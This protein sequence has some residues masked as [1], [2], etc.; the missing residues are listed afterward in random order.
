MMLGA[1][2]L[3]WASRDYSVV[4]P[5]WDGQ[6]RGIA[7]TPSHLYSDA[8]LKNVTPDQI[9]RDLTQLSQ[10]TGRIRTYTVAGGMDKVPQIARR[11][12]MTVTLGLYLTPDLE[13]NEKE[14][15]LGIKTALANRRTIDRVVVGNE[16]QVFGLVSPEQ[17]NAY[18]LR[19]RDALPARI[20]VTTAEPWSTWVL[21]WVPELPKIELPE[22]ELPPPPPPPLLLLLPP[23]LPPPLLV[24]DSAVERSNRG[25]F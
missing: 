20:K 13:Q 23:P 21:V 25:A 8:A 11:Y 5:N 3:F 9:D 16:T 14:I 15:E 17:L 10:I 12:G 4:A 18:I 7:Y 24:L 6:V 22:L 2:V 19:V 1:S